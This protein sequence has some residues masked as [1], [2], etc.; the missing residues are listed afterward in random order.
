[1]NVLEA[2][3]WFLWLALGAILVA[4]EGWGEVLGTAILMGCFVLARGKRVVL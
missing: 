3:A 1:M 4:P 2:I